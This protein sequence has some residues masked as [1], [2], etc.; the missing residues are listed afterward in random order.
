MAK[1]KK[2]YW[3]KLKDDFFRQLHVKKLRKIAGGDTYTIIYL[4]M[5]LLSMN[6]EGIIS[7]DCDKDKVIE[8]LALDI[9]E[10][11]DNVRVTVNFLLANNI[12]EENNDN[13][14]LPEVPV[15]VGSETNYAEK[16]RRL[17]N[18]KGGNNVT[19]VLP[20][21]YPNVTPMLPF[22][23]PSVT[24]KGEQCY[25][26]KEIDIDKDIDNNI[27]TKNGGC[28]CD[29]K[30]SKTIAKAENKAS[31]EEQLSLQADFD[32]FWTI[33]PRHVSKKESLKAYIKAR[34]KVSADV[35]L[36]ALR[37]V[38][39]KVWI[40]RELQHV[41]HASTWLNQERWNDEVQEQK[42]VDVLDTL[43]LESNPFD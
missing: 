29:S 1:V 31:K 26:E 8:N 42:K 3:F 18:T 33:Y 34:K 38:K 19:P 11:E 5:L 15:S 27:S 35:I 2:F 22:C 28:V 21:C 30:Q 23:Y 39:A 7:Y 40:N 17:R 10:D 13:L 32:F 20:Q 6:S 14:F 25:R 9:D 36:E 24:Q 37:E 43:D 12:L 16:M 4:K 41:P